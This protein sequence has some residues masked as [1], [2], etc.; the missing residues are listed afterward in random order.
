MNESTI[1][2]LL[3]F[4]TFTADG[5]KYLLIPCED[6]LRGR[7]R[8]DFEL[9]QDGGIPTNLQ[10]VSPPV[11]E[12]E[13]PIPQSIYI[14]EAIQKIYPK[15]SKDK[16][17]QDVADYLNVIAQAWHY[18]NLGFQTSLLKKAAASKP[19]LNGVIFTAYGKEGDEYLKEL[20]LH[21]MSYIKLYWEEHKDSSS[22]K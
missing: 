12:V 9:E 7:I 17:A 10:P 15:T 16:M 5:I 3:K 22:G 4:E 11:P 6:I 1:Q 19:A 2:A 20:V 21:N 13:T 18:R 8:I 14:P